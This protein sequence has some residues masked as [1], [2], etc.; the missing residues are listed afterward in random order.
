MLPPLSLWVLQRNRRQLILK[1]L[2]FPATPSQLSRWTNLSEDA[3]SYTLVE[4]RSR[5]LARCVNP[6]A[7]RFRLYLLTRIGHQCRLSL[8]GRSDVSCRVRRFPVVFWRL[9]AQMLYPHRCA[10]IRTLTRPMQAA[11]V[12]RRASM[13]DSN[14]RI[15][16]GNVREVLK[17]LL[18]QGIVRKFYVHRSAYPLYERTDLGNQLQD[19]LTEAEVRRW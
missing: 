10:V 6:G 12:K 3:C 4:F 2:V 17:Y 13:N 8:I 9:Y 15:S 5:K 14:L 7:A 18:T 16:A 19:V 1:H 11:E